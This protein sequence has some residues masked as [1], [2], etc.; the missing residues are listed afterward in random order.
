M[1]RLILK[2]HIQNLSIDSGKCIHD[3]PTKKEL[4]QLWEMFINNLPYFNPLGLPEVFLHGYKLKQ[5]C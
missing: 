3:F 4:A 2:A 5:S 1:M